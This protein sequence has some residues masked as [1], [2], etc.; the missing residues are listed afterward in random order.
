M[1]KKFYVLLMAMISLFMTSCKPEV[2]NHVVTFNANGGAG[3]MESQTFEAEIP[4]QLSP[5]TFTYEGH[6]FAGWATTTTGAVE[7]ADQADYT[8]TEDATLYA[9]WNT[10][11]GQ[12]EGMVYVAGGTFEMGSDDYSSDERPVHTVTVGSFYM[13]PHEVTQA[14]WEAVMGENPSD[15]D[16][17]N[18]PVETITWYDAIEFCNALSTSEGLTP[19]YTINGI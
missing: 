12:I 10:T 14:Q 19:C 11:G 5:N 7:Y 9:V 6:T 1:K 2:E 3:E 4:A 13:S 8:A 17:S 16:G 18:L 15:F